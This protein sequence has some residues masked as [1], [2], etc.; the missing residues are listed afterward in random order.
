MR[1]PDEEPRPILG[2]EDVTYLRELEPVPQRLRSIEQWQQAAAKAAEI[3]GVT[4]VSPLVSGAAFALRGAASKSVAIMGIDAAQYTQVI[5]ITE[6]VERGD[7]TVTGSDAV[8]GK[9]LAADL[10]VGLGDTIRIT[11]AERPDGALFTIRG[12]FDLGMRDLNLRWVYVSIRNAQTLLDLVGGVTHIDLRVDDI[13]AADS[14]AEE[15]AARTALTAESWM[16][17]NAQLMT[18]LQ[19]QS[20]SSLM[21]RLFVTI[22]VA[23]GIASVLAISVIQKSREIGILRA[24]GSSPRRIRYV[25]LLQGF[26]VGLIGSA[27]GLLLGVGLVKAFE[28][29]AGDLLFPIP[30]TGELVG[31]A[32]LTALVTGLAASYA[33]AR[34]AAKLD[35]AEAI[36]A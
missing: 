4:A 33:P 8:L 32:L 2:Q 13:F 31:M 25:F 34:R 7:F 14:V 16:D 30:L 3:P 21:I 36:H 35:P 29:V 9:E 19:S 22:A 5:P 10:G 11:T 23:L 17:L 12:I 27:A 15:A 6:Y 1:M 28:Y 24:M 26:L 20:F 18:A